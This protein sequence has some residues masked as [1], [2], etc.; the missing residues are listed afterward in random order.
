M[1]PNFRYVQAKSLREAVKH[2]G[3]RET[4]LHAGGTDLLGCLHDRVFGAEKGVSISRIK[5]LR[6]IRKTAEGGLRIGA[7]T[8]LTEVAENPLIKGLY[9]GLAQAEFLPQ[10]QGEKGLGFRPGRHGT[11]PPA[12]RGGSQTCPRRIQRGGA[13]AMALLGGGRGDPRE[14]A[15]EGNGEKSG[16]C[17]SEERRAHGKKR[18]QGPPA[19]SRCRGGALCCDKAHTVNLTQRWINKDVSCFIVT[20]KSPPNTSIP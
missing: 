4:W 2:L 15:R 12:R 11:R 3:G 18:L 8:T 16:R 17:R 1:L 7:L 14:E 13:C 5:A 20:R 10:G 6:G 19:Q 9:P